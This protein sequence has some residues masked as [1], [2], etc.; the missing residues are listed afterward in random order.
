MGTSAVIAC[1]AWAGD[2]R[3]AKADGLFPPYGEPLQSDKVSVYTNPV[4]WEVMRQAGFTSARVF[5]AVG[6]FEKYIR[7]ALG[8]E[9]GDGGI[10]AGGLDYTVVMN[11][12]HAIGK[13]SMPECET[14]HDKEGVFALDLYNSSF[15]FL[16]GNK[17]VGAF[18]SGSY[19]LPSVPGPGL[20]RGLLGYQAIMGPVL[21]YGLWWL[22]L[23]GKKAFSY[24]MPGSMEGVAGGYLR[25]GPVNAYAGY[26]LSQG[27]FADIGLPAFSPFATAAITDQLEQASLLK[28]GLRQFD[29]F[30]ARSL[31][32]TIGQTSIFARRL[33][34]NPPKTLANGTSVVD[35][36]SDAGAI[37]KIPLTTGA[38]RANRHHGICRCP[39]CL[40]REA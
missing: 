16:Y 34:L 23:F 20:N 38:C 17:Y 27:V 31:V 15:A 13:C 14:L 29:Y 33:L 7:P 36:L 5:G 3:S 1:A 26:I 2:S 25:A 18:A 12:A 22:R 30:G 21:V 10:L 28:A 4:R 37:R 39:R 19:T 24:F 9:V 35:D 8:R 6:A 40:C 32:D 11:A